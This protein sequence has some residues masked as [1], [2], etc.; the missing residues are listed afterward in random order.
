MT[1]FSRGVQLVYCAKFTL[2][3]SHNGNPVIRNN[4]KR[5]KIHKKLGSHFNGTERARF[6]TFAISIVAAV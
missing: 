4:Y 6:A 5:D 2:T 3:V 1:N